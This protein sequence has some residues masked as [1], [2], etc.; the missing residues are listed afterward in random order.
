MTSPL[1]R[2]LAAPGLALTEAKRVFGDAATV[3]YGGRWATAG[4]EMDERTE[5][6]AMELS[7]W[8]D[9]PLETLLFCLRGLPSKGEP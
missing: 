7:V 1:D 8:S 6:D 9:A 5:V 4:I 2:I 3:M